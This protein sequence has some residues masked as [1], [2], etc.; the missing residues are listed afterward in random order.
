[1]LSSRM[2]VLK[3]STPVV[4]WDLSSLTTY[5]SFFFLVMSHFLCF[6]ALFVLSQH[7]YPLF[8]V[9]DFPFCVQTLDLLASI[10]SQSLTV[11]MKTP[12]P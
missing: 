8:L 4:F 7:L 6:T 11:R 5:K 9:S 1:M 12:L 3:S 10:L 2:V